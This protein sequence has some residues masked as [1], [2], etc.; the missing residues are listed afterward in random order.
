MSRIRAIVQYIGTNYSGF[1]SQPNAISVQSVL[2]KTLSGFLGEDIT[3]T[4]SGRT[5]AGVHALAQTIHFDIVR[6]F[7]IERLPYALERLL[8]EDIAILSAEKTTDDFHARYDCISKTYEYYAVISRVKLPIY[9][10]RAYI[11]DYDLDIERMRRAASDMT[12]KRDYS[13]FMASGSNV[14]NTVR[15]VTEFT[16]EEI[17]NNVIRFRVSADGFLYNMV[18][19]MVGTL[20][21]VGRGKIPVEDVK[22]I[23]KTGDRRNAGATAPACGLYLVRA[24][25]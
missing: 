1:Q 15:E 14:M 19:N 9:T 2:E 25:Y 4:A 24:V 5:D 20:I 11:C 16:I 12:G 23:I 3:I 13:A 10:D 22:G 18:R 6:D 17:T 8:P 7:P 21:D